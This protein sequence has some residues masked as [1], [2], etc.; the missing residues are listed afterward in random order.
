MKAYFGEKENINK[1]SLN[2]IKIISQRYMEENPETIFVHRAN[3]TDYFKCEPDGRYILDFD[4]KFPNAVN[5]D[6]AYAFAKIYSRVSRNMVL[7][8][9]AR[10]PMELF[11]NGEKIAQT[12]IYDE[13]IND[14]RIINFDIKEGYNTVFV[15]CR[16]NALGF[17]CIVG[18]TNYRWIPIHFY[19][20]FAENE[21]ELG[22]NYC[23]VFKKDIFETIPTENDIMSE[24][25]LPRPYVNEFSKGTPEQKSM[26]AITQIHCVQPEEIRL[27]CTSDS[28]LELYID[29]ELILESNQK[30]DA[31]MQLEQGTYNVAVKVFNMQKECSF[32]AD[33]KNAEFML[34]EYIKIRGNWL[35]LDTDEEKAKEGFKAFEL[36]TSNITGKKEYFRCGKDVYIR[37]VLESNIFGKSSYPI[38]VVLY[39]LLTAGEYLKDE[40]IS[41]YAHNHLKCCYE[42]MAYCLWDGERYGFPCIN[43]Q[44]YALETLDDCGSFSAT[45]LEDYLHYHKHESVVLFS[46]YIA[47][48]ILNRQER[49]ENGMFYRERKG[50]HHQFTI[51]ADDLYMSTP[52]MIRYAE[53]TGN[54]AILDDVVNQFLCFKEK[55]YMRE[56]KLMGHVYNLK[57][58]KSTKIPWGRGNGWVL[59]SLTELLAI[60]PLKHKCYKEIKDFFVEL[61]QGFLNCIDQYGM[62]HQVLWDEE[63]YAETS[64]TAMC[65][66]SFA[67]GVR[68][69]ILPEETFKEASERC[70]EGLKK[71]CI[72]IDGNVYGVCCGSGYS[73]REEYY[74][75]ELPW[76]LNDTH[77]T[78]I[79]L[80]AIAEVEKNK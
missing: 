18:G 8:I 31:C 30:I 76:I 66:A 54:A 47:D 79:V 5:G 28:D 40:I 55:L 29:G 16:K 14:K 46:N 23:G 6:F 20:A 53:L 32:T 62:L 73:Y 9:S 78:G 24:M 64:C 57:Y 56:Y 50:T 61:S 52:F 33:V 39:G 12:N 60:L 72:D 7:S 3:S 22:W 70:V 37:P 45:V 74:K 42:S 19:T 77:G 1:K 41:E 36:Y 65:A 58:D 11:I 17:K 67:R 15:K 80:I 68:W 25:W 43:H 2:A 13:A 59:F 44:L 38:G 71:Y 48:Y 27:T 51:W 69:G 49:L 21:G 35:Y 10:S 75:Y 63:S 26:Y 34:P 4:E